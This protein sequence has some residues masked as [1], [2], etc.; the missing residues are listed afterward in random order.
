MAGSSLGFLLFLVLEEVV[1]R[2]RP[3]ILLPLTWRSLYRVLLTL[4]F[5]FL[6]LIL[7][8]FDTVDRGILDFVLSRFG[9]LV[10][11]GMSTFS[12]MLLLGF[13]LN[14][15]VVLIVAGL[16]MGGIRQGVHLEHGVLCGSL[17]P[18]V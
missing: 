10:G 3:G 7:S 14:Y 8:S 16:V 18:T 4:M 1:A 2:L 6:Y 13:G 17:S 9:L 5:I 15:H 11:L 12:I